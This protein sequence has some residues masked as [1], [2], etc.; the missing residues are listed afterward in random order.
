MRRIVILAEGSLTPRRAKTALGVIRYSPDAVVAVVDS[1]HAGE[2]VAAALGDPQGVGQ[3]IPVVADVADAFQ[4]NPD[5]LLIGI[6]PVGGQ[7]PA[8]WKSQ[9]VRAMAQGMSVVSG[10]HSF[11]ADDP[12]LAQAA[13]E[14][15]VELWDVRRPPDALATRI[16]EATPHRPGSHTVYFSGTDCAV[17]KMTVA[18]EVDRE[19]RRRGLSSVFAATGQTGILIAGEGIPADRFISDFLPG[20]VE[21]MVVPYAER[22]DWVFVEGQGS[23]LHPAYSAVTLGLLHGSAPDLQILCCRAGQTHID[24]HD[25]AIPPL[26]EV[27]AIYEAAAGWLKPAPT[28]AV[29]VNTFGLSDAEAREAC[30][31][32]A[33]DAGLPATDPVRFGAGPL[34]D[35]LEAF[36]RD[37]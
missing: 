36:V 13:R 28:V 32:A 23:L 22:F 16:R 11:L 29:A 5:T 31:L 21:G 9:I 10:L 19:A 25:V 12:E 27:A 14:Y 7:L 24:E 30:E 35:A 4:F 33:R 34:V 20:G 17:G 1:T 15:S 18:I 26:R 8:A 3:E 37:E 6:A 2:T